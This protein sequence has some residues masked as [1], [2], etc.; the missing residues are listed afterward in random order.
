MATEQTIAQKLKA[1]LIELSPLIDEYTSRKCPDCRDVCCKQRRCSLDAVDS[2][3]VGALGHAAPVYDPARLP[4]G[5]CQFM[6]PNGCIT[7]RWLRPWRCTWYFCDPL[8]EALNSGPPKDARKL[9]A[10]IQDIVDIR[11]SW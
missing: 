4:D 6:G 7:P 5:P 8:L 10:L 1:L 2:R 11:S 3:Y 9:S